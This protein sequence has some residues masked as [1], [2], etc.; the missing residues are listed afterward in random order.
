[1]KTSARATL[2]SVIIV[3]V[4]YCLTHISHN[5]LPE[6]SSAALS[7]I[8]DATA[9]PH[10]YA[11]QN[12]DSFGV[13][14]LRS[15]DALRIVP[16][17]VSSYSL[18]SVLNVCHWHTAPHNSGIIGWETVQFPPSKQK[19]ISGFYGSSPFS[20]ANADICN[21]LRCLLD[22]S[23][24]PGKTSPGTVLQFQRSAQTHPLPFR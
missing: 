3:D 21:P 16:Y 10:F 24:L 6:F 15:K 9:S 8:D 20:S 11:L 1:M 23:T 19:K 7:S 2:L 17:F 22:S 14:I 13:M 12:K 5:D 4:V 18:R